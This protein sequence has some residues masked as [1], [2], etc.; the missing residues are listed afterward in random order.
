MPS[1]AGNG[2]TSKSQQL[3]LEKS[4]FKN[5]HVFE[6][7]IFCL[8]FSKKKKNTYHKTFPFSFLS[9]TV[10]PSWYKMWEALRVK[11]K[12]FFV[13]SG[14]QFLSWETVSQVSLQGDFIQTSEYIDLS[15]SGS[16]QPPAMHTLLS[17]TLSTYCILDIVSYKRA[18]KLPHSSRKSQNIPLD[19]GR[20]A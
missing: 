10:D 15:T 6:T 16:T 2:E 13:S 20:C 5:V 8:V 9:L 7:W 11:A 1:P 19:R 12:A 17:L 3:I 4:L 14:Y 18:V